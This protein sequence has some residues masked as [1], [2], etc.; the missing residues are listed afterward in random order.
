MRSIE[1]LSEM[2]SFFE[3]VSCVRHFPKKVTAEP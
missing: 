1:L 2:G 3:Y